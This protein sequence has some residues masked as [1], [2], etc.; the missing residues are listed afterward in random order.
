M[1]IKENSFY[2]RIDI[3]E[4]L[5]IYP[6]WKD[7][8]GN[9]DEYVTMKGGMGASAYV[10]S[11]SSPSTPPFGGGEL[12]NGFL[13]CLVTSA[14][15]SNAAKIPKLELYKIK[16]GIPLHEGSMEM[17]TGNPARTKPSAGEDLYIAGAYMDGENIWK[18]ENFDG[19]D[20]SLGEIIPIRS[21]GTSTVTLEDAYM[22]VGDAVKEIFI[23]GGNFPAGGNKTTNLTRYFA[24][25]SNAQRIPVKPESMKNWKRRWIPRYDKRTKKQKWQI[26]MPFWKW[27]DIKG[28]LNFAKTQQVST[29][30]E[31]T[32][33]ASKNNTIFNEVSMTPN[34]NNPFTFNTT[35]KPLIYSTIELTS[36]KKSTGGQS[37]RVYHNWSHISDPP[38][39][40]T[41]RRTF[42]IWC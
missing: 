1:D 38:R 22:D 34:Q 25:P 5:G 26:Y 12:S 40:K 4:A 3:T 33:E 14:D 37:L 16:S 41:Y 18:E 11:G 24:D 21:I 10:L 8:A 31:T 29:T 27:K 9:N 28:H 30:I 13:R 36:A 39:P 6:Q 19:T 35:T 32:V 17:A 20:K 15:L 7:F 2:R 23:G 42:F